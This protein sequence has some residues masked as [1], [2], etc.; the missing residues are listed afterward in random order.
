LGMEVHTDEH[1]RHTITKPAVTAIATKELGYK[2]ESSE[3]KLSRKAAAQGILL[4]GPDNVVS[5]LY[6]YG[7]MPPIS[8]SVDAIVTAAMSYMRVWIPRNGVFAG[9]FKRQ[10]NLFVEA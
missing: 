9:N 7:G 3:G 6:A 2:R 5:S 10:L 1:G 4:V 8:G